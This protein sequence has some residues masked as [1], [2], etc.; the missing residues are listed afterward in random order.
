ML[1][2]LPLTT[3]CFAVWFSRYHVKLVDFV[4]IVLRCLILSASCSTWPSQRRNLTSHCLMS[5]ISSFAIW[6]DFHG[7]K[8]FDLS[9]FFSCCLTFSTSCQAARFFFNMSCYLIL[10]SKCYIVWPEAHG[11]LNENQ[12]PHEPGNRWADLGNMPGSADDSHPQ[13]RSQNGCNA[14]FSIVQHVKQKTW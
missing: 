12:R 10:W 13:R 3:S 8:L 1:R 4:F 2:R 6:F 11:R 14:Q 7:A 9:C 5:F